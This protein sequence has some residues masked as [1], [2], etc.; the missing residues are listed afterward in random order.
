MEGVFSEVEP[1]HVTVISCLWWKGLV[2]ASVE[3][4]G[5]RTRY[6]QLCRVDELDRPRDQGGQGH[7]AATRSIR[8]THREAWS[9]VGASLLD[10]RSLRPR[11][12]IRS[13]RRRECHRRAARTCLC[14]Q[15]EDYDASG[16]RQRRDVWEHTKNRL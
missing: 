15:N 10:R 1:V 13:P 6:A 11:R 2:P 4:G 7:R 5:R 8:C 3:A 12:Y 14:W 16:L 9:E